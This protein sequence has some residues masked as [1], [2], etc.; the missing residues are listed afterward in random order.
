M[1]AAGFS[2]FSF[3]D[4]CAKHLGENFN[5]FQI[6]WSISICAMIFLLV[7]SPWLGG[8]KK[9]LKTKKLKL[10]IIRGILCF[11]MTLGAFFSL[12][13]LPMS[14]VYILFFCAPF[15]TAILS[16]PLLKQKVEIYKW[17]TIIIGF[18][19]IVIAF[20]PGFAP[21]E[22]ASIIT[23]AAAVIFSLQCLMVRTIGEDDTPMSFAFYPYICTIILLAI[24]ALLNFQI[25]GLAETFLVI[26]AGAFFAIGSLL[27]A[28][29]FR[30]A[31][32]ATAAPFHYIQMIWGIVLGLIFFGD[33]PDNWMITGSIIVTTSGLY[34][35]KMEKNKTDRN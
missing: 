14:S 30:F 16:L 5:T 17:I 23:L 21:I 25:T 2:S 9:T 22:P 24:P 13:M 18:S 33:I 10:H 4:V 7:T 34:L 3:G 6:T 1:A 31:P 12:S 20:R 29:A 28:L 27:T 15:F 35:L 8:I 19:G 11:L 32:A 26:I